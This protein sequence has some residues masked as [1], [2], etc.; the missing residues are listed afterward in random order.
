[1]SKQP[2]CSFR[3]LKVYQLAFTYSVEVYNLV[4][5]VP[6]G[7]D[8]ALAQKLLARSQAVRRHIA[9]AWGQRHDLTGLVE[10]LSAA[11]LEV[12]EVQMLIEAAIGVGHLNA[13]IGQDL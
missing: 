7:S 6:Q 2:I 5:Q 3:S 8:L 4:Q 10:S 12:T 13:D 1:M 11:Q 9:D